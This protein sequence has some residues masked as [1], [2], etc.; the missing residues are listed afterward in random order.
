[1]FSSTYLAKIRPTPISSKPFEDG[2]ENLDILMAKIIKRTGKWIEWTRARRK[3]TSSAF[4]QPTPEATTSSTLGGT[5]SS[6]PSRAQN[7]LPPTSGGDQ[8]PEKNITLNKT[9]PDGSVPVTK[10]E[11]E[12]EKKKAEDPK[13]S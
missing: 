3:R 11:V 12:T 13:D 7:S 9:C 2:T 6:T 10:V 1:M 4:V 5:S 8:S